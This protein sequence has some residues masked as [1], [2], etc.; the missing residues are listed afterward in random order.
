M[1][2][3]FNNP[4]PHQRTTTTVRGRARVPVPPWVPQPDDSPPASATPLVPGVCDACPA[5]ARA[6]FVGITVSLPDR[7]TVQE[8]SVS[9][10]HLCGH[11]ADRA[12]PLL[13][14]AGWMAVADTRSRIAG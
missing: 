14:Q 12:E 1:P 5:A 9:E 6:L 13:E 11:H 4:A 8:V 2:P 7:W 10:L 3:L